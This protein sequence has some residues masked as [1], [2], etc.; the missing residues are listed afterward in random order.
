MIMSQPI[1]QICLI[2][3]VTVCAYLLTLVQRVVVFYAYI[4]FNNLDLN[5][6]DTYDFTVKLL[7]E[8]ST[9]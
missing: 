9:M 2:Y 5:T 1:E 3:A 7:F 6:M 4:I 8:L